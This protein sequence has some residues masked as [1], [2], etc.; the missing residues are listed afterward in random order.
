[1]TDQQMLISQSFN[2]EV[3]DP[4]KMD[5][6]NTPLYDTVTLAA[7]A[8]VTSLTTAFFTSVGP[9]SG[10]TLAQTNMTQAN[11][12]QAPQAFSIFGF[13]FRWSE[14][15]LRADLITLVNTFALNFTLGQKSYQLGPLWYYAAGGGIWAATT[16]TA[17]SVYTN[18]LPTRES[19]HKLGITLVIENTMSFAASL[20][21]AATYTLT[22]GAS[23]GTGATL[24]LLL[25]GLY[26]RGVQ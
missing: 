6:Q 4:L 14:D 10:K 8:A 5:V 24:Q 18:G 17:E 21:G 2:S 12:L 19:M 1:M 9:S 7:A 25:D 15:I 23:G 13:R 22:A 20:V 16:R 26:A 11:I 3:Y